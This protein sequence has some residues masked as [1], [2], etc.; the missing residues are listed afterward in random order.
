M[1]WSIICKLGGLRGDDGDTHMYETIERL[2]CLVKSLWFY[3]ETVR[4]C[5]RILCRK[6]NVLV[7]CAHRKILN[8]PGGGWRNPRTEDRSSVKGAVQQTRKEVMAA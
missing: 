2:S 5:F 4:S 7:R 8:L 1:D 3:L 6:T